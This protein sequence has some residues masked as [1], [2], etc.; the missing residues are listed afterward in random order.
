MQNRVQQWERNN[1]GTS[2]SALSTE[3]NLDRVKK[4]IL[5]KGHLKKLPV[6]EGDMALTQCD[7]TV[8][9][10]SDS[11]NLYLKPF[12]QTVVPSQGVESRVFIENW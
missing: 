4:K 11:E 3:F 9:T 1:A 8:Q 10:V 12:D 5:G 7:R 6:R 2:E